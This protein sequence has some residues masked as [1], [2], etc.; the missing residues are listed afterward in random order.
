M[1]DSPHGLDWTLV[2]SFLL[3]AQNGSLSAAARASGVSQPTLGRQ[4]KALEDRLGV[5]LFVRQAK[6]LNLSEAGDALLGPAM[7]MAE[8][9]GQFAMHAAGRDMSVSGTVRITASE[10]VS[11][12]ILPDILAQ[13]RAAHRDIQIELHPTDASDNLLFREA[14]IA[15]RMYRPTQLE[16]LTKYLGQLKLGFF[17][18]EMY[19]AER[20]TPGNISELMHHDLLGYD[21]SERFI[22]GAAEFG[23]E[24]NKTNFAIRCDQQ[25]IHGQLIAAGAGIGILPTK[26]GRE[27]LNL[28]PVMEGFPVPGLEVWLTTHEAMRAT[29][30]V[31]AVWQVLAAGL[32]PW[33]SA[34]AKGPRK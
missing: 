26:V 9:A 30:R 16:V 14:D 31:N 19:L 28:M 17:A 5:A 15:V 1:N 2:Q 18:S 10:F 24:L 22:E 7:A 25:A 20:G 12:Y 4:I 21:K 23:W 34:D 11:H 32:R 29:P 13:I 33:M 8:A 3:V 27:S 6:G